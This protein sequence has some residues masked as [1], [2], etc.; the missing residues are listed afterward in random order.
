MIGPFLFLHFDGLAS[1]LFAR[2]VRAF[3]RVLF[4]AAFSPAF[5][6]MI[7]NEGGYVLHTVAGDRGGMTFA[8]IARN[9]WGGWPGWRLVDSGQINSPELRQLVEQFYTDNFWIP[10]GCDDLAADDVAAD[11]FD[12]AVNAGVRVA[13]RLAQV[14]A[15]VSAD[16]VAGP[17]TARAINAMPAELFAVK[18]ALAKVARYAAIV[19]NDRAQGKFL[20][21]WINRT[22][23]GV[24]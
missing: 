11:I 2:F 23:Q 19:N 16:G 20:L 24:A 1:S 14:V 7:H 22:L 17:V 12:F 18:Y 6:Q 5:D 8:G 3:F 21:G 13:V 4:M 10:A 15:G 9:F